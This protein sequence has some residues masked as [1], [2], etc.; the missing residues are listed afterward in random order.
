MRKKSK[1]RNSRKFRFKSLFSRRRSDDET[2]W[3]RFEEESAPVRVSPRKRIRRR[4]FVVKVAAFACLSVSIPLSLHWGYG[5]V[6]FKNE[7]F[8]LKTLQ[9]KT[10]GV[11]SVVRLAEIANVAA[12]MNLMD[13]DLGLIQAQVE[14]L[15]QVEKVTV[16]RELPDRLHLVVRERIPVAWLSVP[17]LGIRPWDMERGFLLD[18][19]GFLFRCLDLNEGMKSLPVIESFKLPEPVEGTRVASE[20]VR[21]GLKLVLESDKRFLERGLVVREVRV[22]DEW[23]VEC[24][25]STD[26]KVTFGIYDYERG[27][28]DLAIILDRMEE[29]GKVVSTVNVAAERNIPVTFASVEVPTPPPATIPAAAPASADPATTP[30]LEAGTPQGNPGNAAGDP[31]ANAGETAPEGSPTASVP[32][33][34]PD[35]SASVAV[36]SDQEKHLRSI[37]KGG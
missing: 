37:L 31:A 27:L 35:E 22:R 29:S 20:G 34:S 30:S 2:D 11:L 6:F 25:Y 10:D 19:E 28:T 15:P 17:P 21:S 3:F 36:A 13:L 1:R 14:K 5:E 23:A 16:T 12:G 33:V 9:V 8:V 26:L 32:V 7:E 24:D 18:E 4:L